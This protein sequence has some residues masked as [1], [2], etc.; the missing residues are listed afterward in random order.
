ML[1]RRVRYKYC[2]QAPSC[3]VD[4]TKLTHLSAFVAQYRCT[5]FPFPRSSERFKRAKSI[6]LSCCLERCNQTLCHM[7]RI[8]HRASSSEK[9]GFVII[10]SPLALLHVCVCMRV[11][12]C[13]CV[14]ESLRGIMGPWLI[15]VDEVRGRTKHNDSHD[16]LPEWPQQLKVYFSLWP[17][18][19][20]RCVSELQPRWVNVGFTDSCWENVSVWRW[21]G[22][23]FKNFIFCLSK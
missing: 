16:S 1:S 11:R 22:C 8:W 9:Q 5:F 21:N 6:R 14:W 19:L 17:W 10:M 13:V 15:G 7:R 3:V 20:R 12:V 2:L 23:S 4:H 18:H